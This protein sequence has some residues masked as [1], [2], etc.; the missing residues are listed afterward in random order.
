MS[1]LFAQSALRAAVRDVARQPAMTRSFSSLPTLRP[2]ISA[3]PSIFARRPATGLLMPSTFTPAAATTGAADAMGGTLT[4]DVVPSTA[5]TSHP[6]LAGVGSQI[7][8]GPRRH[9]NMNR[10]SRLIR[11][12]RHGFLSRIRTKTGRKTLQR[13][14]IKGRKMLS[15]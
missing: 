1:R 11:M 3:P 2:G 8:C 10:P 12:R 14:K 9:M 15:A 4:A 7:R 5:I 6:A 13:R